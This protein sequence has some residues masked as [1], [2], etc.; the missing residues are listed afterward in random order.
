M[1][2]MYIEGVFAYIAL[3]L[4]IWLTVS[5]SDRPT[6]HFAGSTESASN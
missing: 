4:I 2:P 3:C 5:L 1:N 6:R